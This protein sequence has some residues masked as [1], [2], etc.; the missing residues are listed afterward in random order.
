MKRQKILIELQKNSR[1][2]FTNWEEGK[3]TK[4][5]VMYR[6]KKLVDSKFVTL[7][8][9]YNKQEKTWI[10]ICKTVLNSTIIMKKIEMNFLSFKQEKNIHWVA[11]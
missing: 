9:Y 3:V 2:S 6:I 7:F 10:H 8:L 11:S 4:T 1:S 5:V